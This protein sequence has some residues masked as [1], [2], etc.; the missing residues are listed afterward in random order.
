[1]L[2]KGDRQAPAIILT[3][4]FVFMAISPALIVD[5][6][7]FP[8]DINIGPYVDKVVFKTIGDDILALQSGE[9]DL[10]SGGIHEQDFRTLV[11][12]PDISSSIT[13]RNGYGHLTINCGK[14]PLNI[15]AFRRAFAFAYDKTRVTTELFQGLSQEHDSVVPYPS[16]W[17]IEDTLA[18]HYYTAQVE[19]GNQLLDDAG[20][21]IDPITGYR[22]A[23]D[24]SEFDIVIEYSSSEISVGVALIGVDALRALHINADSCAMDFYEMITRLDNHGDY[25]IVMF[26]YQ[27]SDYDVDWLAYEYWSEFDD[28]PYKNPTNFE[29]DTFDSWRDQLL[30]S[31]SYEEVYEAAAAMQLI[32]HENVPILVV[33]ENMYLQVYRTDKFTGHVYDEGRSITSQWTLRKIHKIDGTP[34][35]KVIV[36]FADPET[37]NVFLYGTVMSAEILLLLWP[38]LYS[39]APDIT[40]W[41]YLAENL[42]IETHSDNPEVPE[43]H[44]RFIIDIIQNA[45]WIDGS[46]LTAEDVAFTFTYILESSLYGNPSASEL[47]DLVAAYAPTPYRAILE[48]KTESSWHF[49]HFAYVK[50]IP[51][52]IFNDVDGIGYEGYKTWNPVFNPEDPY[53]TSGPFTLTDWELGEFYELSA[54]PSFCYYP[55]RPTTTETGNGTPFNLTLAITAGAISAAVVVFVGGFVMFRKK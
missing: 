31:T 4:I 15:S 24:C 39:R 35:G 17:C 23:P 12:D 40:P 46:F 44:T 10:I 18:Y 45:T 50:I 26:A 53:I 16:P 49:S 3:L 13:L 19:L 28:V 8:G 25:D 34:G 41:P 14:Y 27:F 43:G 9:I 32:L 52:H 6:T 33:Y 11:N 21:D 51:K 5:A 54:N 36:A 37:F 7:E 29:N 42:L 47:V 38:T 30:H 55:G 1:M 22:L 2:C 20:F 48:F